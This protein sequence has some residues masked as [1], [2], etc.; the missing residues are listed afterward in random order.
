MKK[1]ALPI[2]LVLIGAA[3][4]ITAIVFWIDSSTSVE[5][6]SFGKTLLDWVT[7]IA[8]LGVSIKGWMDLFKREK[9]TSPNTKIEVNDGNP[10]ISTGDN[11][12]NVQAP[13]YIE[14][15]T[16]QQLPEPSS[17]LLSPM[18]DF[19]GREKKLE[20][21]HQNKQKGVKL[22]ASLDA[23]I[24]PEDYD[25][26]FRQEFLLKFFKFIRNASSFYV[27]SGSGVGKTTLLNFL[28]QENIQR[29][30]LGEQASN[31][32][33]VKVN[34]FLLE[35]VKDPWSFYELL[36]STMLR[37]S[38]KLEE[39]ENVRAM[40]A[41]LDSDLLKDQNPSKALRFFH[42][43]TN[44]ICQRYYIKLCFI[45]DEFDAHYKNLPNEI[46]SQLRAVREENRR[47]LLYIFFLRNIPEKLR[48][49]ADIPS[50]YELI[51]GNAIGLEP[52]TMT[53]SLNLLRRL[54]ITHE[55]KLTP[56]L[57]EKICIASGGHA[58]MIAAIFSNFVEHPSIADVISKENWLEWLGT[59]ELVIEECEKIW[60]SLDAEEKQ[61]LLLVAQNEINKTI[62]SAMK[63][64]IFRG[65]LKSSEGTLQIFSPLFKNYILSKRN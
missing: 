19:V 8:G 35:T 48:S 65:L 7:L 57:S 12:R 13:T 3:L 31:T 58:G 5:P 30:Y 39:L 23:E 62:I 61:N 54:G 36:I 28:H 20:Q 43:A 53:D 2:T 40:L 44:M 50:I 47:N 32:W 29:H 33:I 63:L 18:L 22:I 11:V 26:L 51:S 34:P 45:F 49:P 55:Y 52:Y 16:I 60:E 17:Q 25:I 24:A 42:L 64:L 15:L 4:L 14:H 1:K 21:L 9:I 41:D 56:E 10:Q 6:Q 37:E 46:F 27:L 38:P 59:R